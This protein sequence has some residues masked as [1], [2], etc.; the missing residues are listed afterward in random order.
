MNGTKISVAAKDAA[1][2]TV[3]VQLGPVGDID[4]KLTSPAH[5]R[6]QEF[7]NPTSIKFSVVVTVPVGKVKR[8]EFA[9][10]GRQNIVATDVAAPYERSINVKKLSAGRHSI[11]ATAYD[12]FGYS[13]YTRV[14]IDITR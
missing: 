13:S 6:I 2:L 14:R 4:V 1:K 10:D 11:Y 5:G 8:V 3:D 7:N 9:I 12:E